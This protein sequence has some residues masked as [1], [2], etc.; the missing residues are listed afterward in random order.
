[1]EKSIEAKTIKSILQI[2]G[3]NENLLNKNHSVTISVKMGL[4]N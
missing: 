1:M 4:L 3:F 2:Y